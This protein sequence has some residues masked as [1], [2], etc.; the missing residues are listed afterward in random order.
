MQN[1]DGLRAV[2]NT[3]D[4][5]CVVQGV[6]VAKGQWQKSWLNISPRV[7]GRAQLGGQA[8]AEASLI[9]PKVLPQNSGFDLQQT[10]DEAQ[11][12]YSE[13]GHLGSVDLN[14]GESLVQQK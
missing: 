7:K 10:V 5:G 4:G 11:A 2:K 12:D 8:F 13:S 9:I 6:S 1:R 14:T 3:I